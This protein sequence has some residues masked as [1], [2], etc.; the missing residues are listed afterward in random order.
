MKKCPICLEELLN[1][2]D[3]CPRCGKIHYSSNF[4]ASDG[5]FIYDRESKKYIKTNAKLYATEL[6]FAYDKGSF[7]GLTAG[8]A[9]AGGAIGAVVGGLADSAIRAAKSSVK[10]ASTAVCYYWKDI[11]SLAYPA[12]PIQTNILGI[13]GSRKVG[14]RGIDMRLKD[15]TWLT[16]GIPGFSKESGKDLYQ[17][18][19]ALHQKS[20]AQESANQTEYENAGTVHAAAVETARQDFMAGAASESGMPKFFK[21]SY[22]GVTQMREGDFCAYCGKPEPEPE[23]PQETGKRETLEQETESVTGVIVCPGCGNRQ[24]GGKFCFQCGRKLTEEKPVEKSCPYCGAKVKDGMLFC[25][26]CGTRL[27]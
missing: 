1:A 7:N 3:D 5:A 16:L 13:Q 26:E 27:T 8:G 17:I 22:C 24:E 20:I 9:A 23:P 2:G 18:M 21:C 15:G 25:M 19:Y 12:E 6:F 14:G 11:S 4:S 10:K